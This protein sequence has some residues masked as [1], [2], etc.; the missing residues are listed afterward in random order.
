[1]PGPAFAKRE[2]PVVLFICQFGTVKSA[3]TRELFRQRA[4]ERGIAVVALSRGITPG[5]HLAP[6]LQ[7]QLLA[8]G[9]D[10]AHD[11]LKQLSSG[12][13][14]LADVTV[15]FDPLPPGLPTHRLQDWRDIGSFNDN[16]ATER[17]RVIARIDALL[18]WISAPDLE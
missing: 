15:T 14:S 4:R 16:Y 1:L 11:S 6:A 13:L 10:P 12:D 18:D 3:I 5:Q 7:R 9:I 2:Q 17:A 8:E